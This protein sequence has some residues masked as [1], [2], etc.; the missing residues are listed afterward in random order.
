MH[1]LKGNVPT[2]GKWTVIWLDF[3]LYSFML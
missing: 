1:V 2:D 3:H